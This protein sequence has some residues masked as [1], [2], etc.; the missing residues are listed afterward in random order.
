MR[1]LATVLKRSDTFREH[2]TGDFKETADQ[3]LLAVLDTIRS[4]ELSNDF[5][6]FLFKDCRRS[7]A[8]LFQDLWVLHQTGER[9]GGYFVEFGATNGKDLSNTFLL[10]RDYGWHGIL[11]EPNPEW[12]SDLV[13]NRPTSNIDLRCVYSETGQTLQFAASNDAEYGT[14]IS[15]FRYANARA[16]NFRPIPVETISLNDLLTEHHAPTDIDYISI[17]TEGSELQILETFDF[18]KWNVSLFTIEHNYSDQQPL[19]DA[20]MHSKGYRRDRADRSH[21]DAWYVKENF[22]PS[23]VR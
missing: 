9:H 1:A 2:I 8:Q 19:I 17:D 10:E 12:H 22:R 23:S 18:S 6:E 5:D 4:G 3:K 7:F 11:A 21:W 13:I 16:A 20:L 14:L 15:H